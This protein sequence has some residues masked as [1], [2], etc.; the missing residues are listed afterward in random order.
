MKTWIFDV[1]GVITNLQTRKVEHPEILDHIVQRL[2]S[3]EPVGI[4][5]G[6]ELEWLRI[7]VV[8]EIENLVEDKNLLDLLCIECEFG[9][10]SVRH[11]NGDSSKEKDKDFSIPQ[12]LISKL[13]EILS[14]EFGDVFFDPG[15]ETHFTAEIKHELN[16]KDYDDRKEELAQKLQKVVDEMGLSDEIEVHVDALAVNVK[17]KKLNKHLATDKFLKWLHGKNIEPEIYYVFGD[18]KTDLQIA[19]EL[20]SQNKKVK[21]IYTGKDDLGNL[22]FEI[23]RTTK[24]YDE[25]TLEYLLSN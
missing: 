1:D 16:P 21:F 9:G 4:I 19:E 25:G 7:G 3:G 13:K 12:E 20:H 15:K 22:P 17:H 8:K 11:E 10:I 5:T 24:H 6:R 14:S 18:S 23:V 2:K